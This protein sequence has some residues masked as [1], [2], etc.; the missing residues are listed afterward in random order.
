MPL[1]DPVARKAYAKDYTE[2]TKEK[3]KEI[4]EQNK[5]KYREYY[6]ENK[7]KLNNYGK[8]RY[9]VIKE[10]IG[11]QKIKVEISEKSQTI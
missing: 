1:K 2:R 6:Q 3:R 4:Y 11:D 9:K 7:E 5:E 10:L 8:A